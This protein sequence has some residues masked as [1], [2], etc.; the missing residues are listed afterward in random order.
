[1]SFHN[2]NN[3]IT[4]API[5]IVERTTLLGYS[6]NKVAEV[7]EK[8]VLIGRKELFIRTIDKMGDMFESMTKILK[9]R[10]P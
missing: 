4:K 8:E 2:F 9:S 5:S 7:T 1:M 10:Q 6:I 3:V